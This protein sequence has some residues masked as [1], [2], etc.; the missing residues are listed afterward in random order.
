LGGTLRI[1]LRQYIQQNFGVLVAPFD[2]FR[3]VLGKQKARDSRE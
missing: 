2:P 1:E 3:R